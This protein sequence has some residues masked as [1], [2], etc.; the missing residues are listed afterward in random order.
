MHYTGMEKRRVGRGYEASPYGYEDAE[1]PPAS[2][3]PKVET[4]R[5]KFTNP[6]GLYKQFT[7]QNIQMALRDS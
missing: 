4:F 2:V 1:K 7:Q 6:E 3:T 5:P